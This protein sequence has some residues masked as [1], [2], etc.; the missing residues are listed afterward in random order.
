MMFRVSQAWER[1]AVWLFVFI[2]GLGFVYFSVVAP[3]D[4]PVS[5]VSGRR[6]RQPGDHEVKIPG[7]C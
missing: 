7:K 2:F 1:W 6:R 3:L 5:L 4:T